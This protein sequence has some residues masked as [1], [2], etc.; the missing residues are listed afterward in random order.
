MDT[1]KGMKGPDILEYDAKSQVQTISPSQ[2]TTYITYV[3]MIY[4]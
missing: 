4:S 2:G 3:N 1:P